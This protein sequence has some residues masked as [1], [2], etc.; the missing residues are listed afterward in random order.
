MDICVFMEY[1]VSNTLDLKVVLEKLV[2][3]KSSTA[4]K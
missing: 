4:A 3:G 2:L 1:T